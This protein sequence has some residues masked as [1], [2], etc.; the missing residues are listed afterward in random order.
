MIFDNLPF[1]EVCN[2][3][4]HATTVEPHTRQGVES[5]KIDEYNWLGWS[6]ARD[7]GAEDL[8]PGPDPVEW[9]HLSSNVRLG[10]PKGKDQWWHLLQVPIFV[11]AIYELLNDEG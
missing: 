6:E 7:Q 8:G 11:E 2:K 4:I 5:H 10:G 1:R 3:I 9:H